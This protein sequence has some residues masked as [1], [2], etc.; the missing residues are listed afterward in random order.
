MLLLITAA[1]LAAPAAALAEDLLYPVAIAVKDQETLYL[2]DRDLPG[3]WKTEGNQLKIFFRGDKKFRTPLNAPRC[4]TVDGEGRLLVGDSA[5]REVYRFNAEGKPEPLT[6]G[7]IGIP[8]GIAVNHAGDLL[9]SDLELHMIWKVPAAGGAPVEF[10]RVAGPGNVCIDGED[11]LWVVSRAENGLVR[12]LPDGKVETVVKGR[13]FQFPHAV[14]VDKAGAAYVCDGYAKTIWKIEADG[15]PQKW[16]TSDSF[17]NPVGLAWRQDALLVVD[18]RA[19]A[20]F[21]INPE[22]KVEPLE[23]KPA[24]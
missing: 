2:V 6:S 3:V 5:T 7:G 10:A 8:M 4:A 13:A 11:R 15:K 16:A 23:L 12:V 19:K 17:A 9:V 24:E 14:V 21:Q 1:A 18:S 20:V 22:G